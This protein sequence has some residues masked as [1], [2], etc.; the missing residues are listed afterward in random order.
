MRRRGSPWFLLL[1]LSC[2]E[3]QPDTALWFPPG[4][5]GAAAA[6]GSAGAAGTT[7]PN[8]PVD[9]PDAAA[10][11]P[12]LPPSAF[13]D[14]HLGYWG[15]VGFEDPVAVS[16][17]QEGNHLFGFGCYRQLQVEFL[18]NPEC[19][20]LA[21]EI[22]GRELRFAFTFSD[23]E[24]ITYAASVVMSEDGQ[25]MAGQFDSRGTPPFELHDIT[26]LTA[27]LPIATPPW[28]TET[29]PWQPFPNWSYDLQLVG[30]QSTGTEFTSAQSYR[31]STSDSGSSIHGDLGSYWHGE[32]TWNEA[33]DQMTIGPLSPTWPT[34][35]T[36]LVLDFT[37]GGGLTQVTATTANGEYVFTTQ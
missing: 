1:A 13:A 17:N 27:W 4:A 16:L 12:A 3:E 9:A 36:L 33:H 24:N 11:T 10:A 20:I 8:G 37:T 23:Y 32:W 7:L 31:F 28:F 22:T 29:P 5:A 14:G 26:Q 18:N 25:R 15:M 30:A 21:G 19:A 35:P 6:T 2:D 34:L